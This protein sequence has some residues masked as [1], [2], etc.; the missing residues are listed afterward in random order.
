MACYL[1][2]IRSEVKKTFYTGVTEDLDQRIISHNTSPGGYTRKFRPWKLVYY[3]S[4]PSC[5]QARKAEAILK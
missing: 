1:Y 2:I 4:F 5:E 3:H